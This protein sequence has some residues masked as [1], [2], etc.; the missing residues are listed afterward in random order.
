MY[1]SST[2]DTIAFLHKEN[3]QLPILQADD[4]DLNS[5][6]LDFLIAENLE[7]AVY[8]VAVASV[9]YATGT[10]TLHSE[11]SPDVGRS[12]TDVKD[13]PNAAISLDSTADGI[14]GPAGD[15]DTYKLDLSG[16]SG[17]M[18]VVF[19]TTTNSTPIVVDTFG[20]L[21]DD[22]GGSIE[23]VGDSD[24]I[25]SPFD[26]FIPKTLEPGIYYIAVVAAQGAGP[27]RL[28]MEEVADATKSIALAGTPASGS[29]V[30]FLGTKPDTDRF[31]FTVSGTK[32][33][34]VYTIGS[35]DTKGKWGSNNSNDDG[36]MHQDTETSFSLITIPFLKAWT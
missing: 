34:F 20:A 1:T 32:E 12:I 36:A 16:K 15:Q 24:F 2:F 13:D 6:N 29:S 10:Y 22:V 5:N 28:H 27:Y 8:Y 25:D 7:P 9:G 23:Q 35:T 11:K 30:G 4:S 14:I 31:T 21:F 18:D 17:D 3:E 33:I 26:F 19:Y